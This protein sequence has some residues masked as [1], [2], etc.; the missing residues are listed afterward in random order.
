MVY[1]VKD[2]TKLEE[3][4]NHVAELFKNATEPDIIKQSAVVEQKIKE[5]EEEQIKLEGD[6]KKLLGDYKDV[7]LHTSFKPNTQDQS[8][9]VPGA[10]D[11]DAAFNQFF[12]GG[13]NE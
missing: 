12:N 10:F 2:M 11:P 6:Y 13:T 3:L 7:V 4:R 8:G 5:A 9:G 1:E